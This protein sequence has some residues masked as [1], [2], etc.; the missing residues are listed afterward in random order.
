MKRK[1]AYF[2]NLYYGRITLKKVDGWSELHQKSSGNKYYFE[3]WELAHTHLLEQAKHRL[4][5]AK[6]E[7]P[8]A[9]RNLERV[10]ALTKGPTP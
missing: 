9:T 8:M 2:V 10:K 7:V 6:A 3:T 4:K 1:R 5:K